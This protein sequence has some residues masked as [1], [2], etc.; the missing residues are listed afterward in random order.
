[1][2]PLAAL[3]AVV[4]LA[5]FP[6]MAYAAAVALLQSWA[7]RVPAG[8]GRV[9]L[10]ELVA[11]A[12]ATAGCGLLAIPDSPLFG[13]PT[14]ASLVG[15]LILFAGGIAWGTSAQWPWHR[16]LAGAAVLLPLL[17]L[18]AAAN[19]LGISTIASAPEQAVR[20]WAGI[21]A[22][23][24]L[25]ALIRPFDPSSSRI[26][27][28]A[29]LAATSLLFASLVTFAPL[30]GLG[31]LWVAGICAAASV[32]YAGLIGLLRRPVIAGATLLGLVAVIPAGVALAIAIG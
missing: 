11:A 4:A 27:R 23:L 12:G 28:S 5:A 19:T 8:E 15:I 6:G 26:S 14:G 3:S 9:R 25:P 7:G 31:A 30:A 22:L 20:I 1:M 2:N 24:A 10:E 16:L 17:G 18:A 32:A 21:A 29:L 13:L